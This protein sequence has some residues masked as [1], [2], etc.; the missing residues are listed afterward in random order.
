MN[1][2]HSFPMPLFS[3]SR[4]LR[5]GCLLAWLGLSLSAACAD[6]ME[7]RGRMSF[8]NAIAD[9]GN[10]PD[11]FLPQY[12]FL[13]GDKSE[14][15]KTA[16]KEIDKFDLHAR[17]YTFT[18]YCML[19]CY[20]HN[21]QLYDEA[22]KQKLLGLLKTPEPYAYHLL[23]YP[24]HAPTANLRMV[25]AT[26]W[27]LA[28]QAFGMENWPKDFP[29]ADDPTRAKWLKRQ[30]TNIVRTGMTEFAS[31][32]YCLPNA[33]P[34]QCLRDLSKDAQLEKQAGIAYE[35]F[36]AQVAPT[37][38]GG[39]WIVSPARSYGDLLSQASNSNISFLWV[40]FG[41]PLGGNPAAL[42]AASFAYKPPGYL[43]EIATK[44]VKPYVATSRISDDKSDIQMA[45]QYPNGLQQYTY[46]DKSYGIFSQITLPNT[47]LSEQ[48]VYGNGVMWDQPEGGNSLLWATVPG[49]GAVHTHG[50][51]QQ[52]LEFEQFEN[53]WMMVG[54]MEPSKELHK[55]AAKL[56]D[57][58]DVPA[59]TIACYIPGSYQ[60][61]I[62]DAATTGRV[63]VGYRSVLVAISLP[64][65]FQWDPSKPIPQRGGKNEA[66]DTGFYY[67][68]D[69]VALAMETACPMDM[70]GATIKEKLENFRNDIAGKTKLTLVDGLANYVNGRGHR[71][72]RR[73]GE[74]GRIDGKPDDISKKLFLSNPWMRQ[75]YQQNPA[76]PC[77]LTISIDGKTHLYDFL[78]WT[79]THTNGP[80]RPTHLAA[81][82]VGGKV[83]LRWMPSLGEPTGYHI[84]RATAKNGPFTDVGI[85]SK[86][87]FDDTKVL[88]GGTYYYKVSATNAGGESTFSPEAVAHVAKGIPATPKNLA[89]EGGD[90][91]VSLTWEPVD[92]ADHYQIYRSTVFGGPYVL[93]GQAEK[94]QLTDSTVKNS[95]TY[96][97][98][99][100]AVNALGEGGCSDED[101]ANP[102]FAL[103]AAPADVTVKMVDGKNVISWQ[104]VPGAAL[105]SIER[106]LT[107]HGLYAARGATTAEITW[108]DT[109]P[110][111]EKPGQWF[112]VSAINEAG[113]GQPSQVIQAQ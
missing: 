50:Q 113:L 13:K 41:G 15:L 85:V 91:K 40:Y 39:H 25:G 14:G 84:Q 28:T 54:K 93:M 87:R 47:P 110:G 108:A 3:V 94:N 69:S 77:T 100:S 10:R 65:P 61:M 68:G 27:H 59:N 53:S 55:P 67:P 2:R 29:P 76:E 86:P 11:R 4:L 71:L 35:A 48:Q 18:V 104:P 96:Y 111:W 24:R 97:Y 70:P 101:N 60:A 78:N 112:R 88:D 79:I 64:A 32:P 63:F 72:E 38:L 19:D 82:P 6:T 23:P 7:D 103:L 30:T 22:H 75:P 81:E 33:M 73:S 52:G 36:L 89:A 42:P 9:K 44:R 37:W 16:Y 95:T 56:P 105:Y 20:L 1:G 26:S 45:R 90:G 99:V 80:S 8:Q 49:P 102:R 107:P 62:D 74:M 17:H 34:L 106:S 58:R 46:M 66:R 83:A 57:G 51:I 92:I 43:E 31:R 98:V 21:P 5:I 109:S 12:Y